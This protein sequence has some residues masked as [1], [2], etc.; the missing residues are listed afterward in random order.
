MR[1]PSFD[2]FQLERTLQRSALSTGTALEGSTSTA[3]DAFAAFPIILAACPLLSSRCS[4]CRAFSS[5]CYLCA[6][7]LRISDGGGFCARAC[8]E[9]AF[10]VSGLGA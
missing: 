5:R 9:G 10:A 1:V 7:E 4:H 2:R 8:G 3:R 6:Q